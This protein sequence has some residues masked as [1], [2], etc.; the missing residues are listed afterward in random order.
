MLAELAEAGQR[1]RP[2]LASEVRSGARPPRIRY[3]HEAMADMLVANPAISQNELATYFGYTPAW[4]STIVRSDAFQA[5]LARRRAEFV[6]PDLL[7]TIRERH[8]A[9][10][11]QSLKVLQE[12]LN[13]PA[14]EVDDM[15]ALKAAELSSKALGMGQQ[16]AVVVTS[17]ERLKALAH[18]LV[19]LQGGTPAGDVVDV[20]ARE[21]GAA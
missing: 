13:K 14:S 11:H 3:T 21:V 8:Q 17:E 16:G 1:A 10:A 12:K 7:L 18:R 20:Q 19:A 4:I 2:P 5:L 9:L 6:D 15:L